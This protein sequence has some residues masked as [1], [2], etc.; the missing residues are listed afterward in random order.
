[1]TV[2]QL[3]S[4]NALR[5]REF[6]VVQEK[7]FLG[8]ANVC[9]LPRRSTAAIQAYSEK[10]H[11][12]DQER[13]VPP[14]FFTRLREKCAQLL[15]VDRSDIALVGPT[16][17]ALSLVAN[18][19]PW[20]RGDN[21][22]Y[23]PDDYPSNAVV[24]MNLAA[25]GIE[26]RPVRTTHPGHIT[27]DHLAPLIDGKTRLVALSSNHFVSGFRLDVDAIGQLVHEKGALFCLDAIQ[28]FGALQ[29]PLT[30]V[31]FACADAHKWLLGPCAAGIFYVSP[32]GREHLEPTLLGWANVIC[33]GFLTPETVEF[34]A[35]ARRYEAGTANILGLVGLDAS[36]DLLLEL[37]LPSIE[38]TVLD[39][40]RFVRE[41]VLAKGYSLALKDESRITANVSFTKA[42]ADLAA[43]HERL[44]EAG[45][46]AS[47]RGTLDGRK[48]LRF[49]PHCFNTSTE[50][51]QACDLL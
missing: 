50:L 44:A 10:S 14:L 26:P 37:G 12:G 27:V 41:M 48:W 4:D 15:G 22:V 24:W 11:T 20:Q 1:M 36:I 8:T 23:S 18:G 32:Q 33:P 42:D 13:Q 38:A 43:S 2:D 28:T 47:L 31:D 16:S 19:L 9:P 25:R 21:V 51:A 6:P 30:H 17:I 29:T 3:Q 49:A 7:I 39:H 45:V 34:P 5:Q 46:V 40:A 35:D